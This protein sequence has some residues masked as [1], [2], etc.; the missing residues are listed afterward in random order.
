MLPSKVLYKFEILFTYLFL[1][2]LIH[3][4]I[5]A[6]CRLW[7][8]QVNL[9]HRLST[10]YPFVMASPSI[11]IIII[12][13]VLNS[14]MVKPI[15]PSLNLKFLGNPGIKTAYECSRWHHSENSQFRQ[16]KLRAY[17]KLVMQN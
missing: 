9:L 1:L 12:T 15:L 4:T 10:L 17:P 2:K 6:F 5:K 8:G 16:A 11:T 7:R 14:V 13:C 3:D